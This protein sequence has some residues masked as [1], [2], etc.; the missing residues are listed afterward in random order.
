VGVFGMATVPAFRRRHA[1]TAVLDALAAWGQERGASRLYLQVMQD[2]LPA[3][4]LYERAGFTTLY[5][6]YYREKKP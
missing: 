1:A 3:L 2:N 4:A 5:E 6:Y